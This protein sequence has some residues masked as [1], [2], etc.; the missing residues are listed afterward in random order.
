MNN[1][2][3]TVPS[4]LLCSGGPGE[5]VA[6]W[7]SCFQRDAGKLQQEHGVNV[8][9]G[10][11]VY[12]LCRFSRVQLFATLWTV[13][14]RDFPGKNTAVGC[15]AP[16]GDLPDPRIKSSIPASPAL[17]VAS[18]P[19]E[20][21]GKPPVLIKGFKIMSM[22]EWIEEL[23]T[24]TLKGKGSLVHGT[25]VDPLVPEGSRALSGSRVCG[26]GRDF[27]ARISRRRMS[28][29]PKTCH[30]AWGGTELCI[31][32]VGVRMGGQGLLLERCCFLDH[33][34]CS[35]KSSG[36]CYSATSLPGNITGLDGG[37]SCPLLV[38]PGPP[39]VVWFLQMAVA[40]LL[41]LMGCPI[42]WALLWEAE[43]AQCPVPSEEWVSLWLQWT[44]DGFLSHWVC[45]PGLSHPFFCR[46]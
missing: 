10:V 36:D 11:H 8:K 17:Q 9:L 39:C 13:A 44:R 32:G 46:V 14:S 2:E 31:P 45:E 7:G 42:P 20:P 21:P 15:Y 35:E 38:G 25:S 27:W 5:G 28:W 19:T 18:L 43:K 40:C 22:E 37:R 3:K 1:W 12:L 30:G 33:G 24:M 26:G 16:P 23:R 6:M 4:P 41:W 34:P 29:L